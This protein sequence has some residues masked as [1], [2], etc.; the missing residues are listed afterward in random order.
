[1][2]CIILPESPAWLC[3]K[4]HHDKAKKS[5]RFLIGNVDGYD[6][7]HE[8]AVIRWDISESDRMLHAAGNGKNPWLLLFK[9]ANLKR[10]LISALPL[11][12]Q[13]SRINP[14]KVS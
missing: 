4:G 13:V 7:E 2:P 11:C 14:L 5:L 1:M 8:Y 10:A 6:L 9:G 12:V 3:R